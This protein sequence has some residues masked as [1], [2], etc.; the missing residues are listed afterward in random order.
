MIRTRKV[1]PSYVQLSSHRNFFHVQEKGNF[2][3]PPAFGRACRGSLRVR[4]YVRLLQPLLSSSPWPPFAM[5]R[6]RLLRYWSSA[7]RRSSARRGLLS[8]AGSAYKSGA[9]GAAEPAAAELGAAAGA[10]PTGR[11]HCAD[12]ALSDGAL[13]PSAV[14]MKRPDLALSLGHGLVCSTAG[15]GPRRRVD[16]RGATRPHQQAW[17]GR[18]A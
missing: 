8:S 18:Y 16:G 7:R 6:H 1:V 15:C 2:H 4:V 3:V 14:S 17:P 5:R 9:A 13:C 10:S 12:P 11:P